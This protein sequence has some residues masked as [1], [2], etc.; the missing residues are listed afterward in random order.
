MNPALPK[1]DLRK[2][3]GGVGYPVLRK[4]GRGE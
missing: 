1:K 3:N 4:E 2:G